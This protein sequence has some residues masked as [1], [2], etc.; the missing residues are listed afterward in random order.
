MTLNL[1]RS[2]LLLAALAVASAGGAYAHTDSPKQQ[3]DASQTSAAAPAAVAVVE[4]FHA[5][6]ARG[7]TAGASVA[8]ADAVIIYEGGRVEQSRAQYA[9][10]HLMAD[11]EFAKAV[12]RELVRRSGGTSGDISWVASEG[13]AKGRFKGRD[14]DQITTETMI[15]RR[16]AGTWRIVHV[17]WSSR[18]ASLAH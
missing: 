2:L 6:L 8:L 15:L 12:A 5:A 11:A 13:R 1:A 14:I 7:D 9:S 3:T 17:H 16:T 10:G 18:S 4:A